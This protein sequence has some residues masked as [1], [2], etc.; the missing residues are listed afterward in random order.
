[1]KYE[2]YLNALFIF[3]TLTFS[4]S[5]ERIKFIHNEKQ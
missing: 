3:I 1:M 2:N 4:N 5:V